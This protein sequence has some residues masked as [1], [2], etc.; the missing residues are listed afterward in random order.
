[1]KADTTPLPMTAPPGPWAMQ[2]TRLDAF[3]RTLAAAPRPASADVAAAIAD[4]DR[5]APQP[6]YTIVDGVALVDVSGVILPSVPWIYELLEIPATGCDR[7]RV[8]LLAASADPAVRA[9]VLTVSSPGGSV[10]GVEQVARQV[11]RL[12]ERKPVVAYVDDLAASAAYWIAS[13]AAAVVA[14]RTAQ[15][16]SIGTFVVLEDASRYWEALGLSSHVIASAPAKTFGDEWSE[17][18]QSAQADDIRDAVRG[19]TDIFIDA[20][21]Q[22]RGTAR[23]AVEAWATGRV[24]MAARARELGLI[25]AVQDFED[26]FDAAQSAAS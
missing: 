1:M 18:M 23:S 9:V 19:I 25:D 22:G 21:A 6:D 26:V 2:R 20:V 4:R 14:N 8:N 3:A 7:L 13:Q 24:W 12:R 5:L 15:I 10:C 16:G 11:L 17:R